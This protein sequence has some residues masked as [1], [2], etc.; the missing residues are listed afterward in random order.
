MTAKTDYEAST[1]QRRP[2]YRYIRAADALPGL[3]DAGTPLARVKLFDPTGGWTWYI[4]A[5]D[6]QTRTAFGLVDGFEKE[7]GYIDMGE[8]VAYRGRFGLPLERDLYWQAC[9]LSSLA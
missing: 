4:S 9:P 8:L 7:Y 3:D 5:Y 6:P 1:F 2:C